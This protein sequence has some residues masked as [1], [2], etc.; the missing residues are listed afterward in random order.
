MEDFVMAYITVLL[1]KRSLSTTTTKKSDI[2]LHPRIIR[3]LNETV[4]F[5]AGALRTQARDALEALSW[6]RN[7]VRELERE[8]Q[9]NDT[10]SRW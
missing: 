6:S 1:Y 9:N 10:C 5:C 8:I 4:P 3:K 2:H 7:N